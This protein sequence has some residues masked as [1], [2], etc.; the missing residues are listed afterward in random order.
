MVLVYT[1]VNHLVWRLCKLLCIHLNIYI[2]HVPSK[3]SSISCIE[4]LFVQLNED[5]RCLSLCWLIYT[6][7]NDH[8]QWV[9]INYAHRNSKHYNC[10][11]IWKSPPTTLGC[12]K[13]AS[14]EKDL[15]WDDA[16]WP[17]TMSSSVFLYI[18]WIPC[19]SR[20]MLNL[21]GFF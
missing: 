4:L 19:K 17:L 14:K 21:R 11:V 20:I 3:V 18:S 8:F 10:C 13:F 9:S 5:I 6:P 7:G 2:S 15:G 12:S 1:L 16:E